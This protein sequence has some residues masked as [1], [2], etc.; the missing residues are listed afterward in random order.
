MSTP[1]ES[2][3]LQD[4]GKFENDP[5]GGYFTVW[6]ILDY[7]MTGTTAALDYIRVGPIFP[8]SSN[9]ELA[10]SMAAEPHTGPIT[11][12]IFDLDTITDDVVEELKDRG[13]E[14]RKLLLTAT[15]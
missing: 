12:S 11:K 1:R 5:E 7:Q 14:V 2:I 4:T 10:K 15:E 6:K 3:T 13:V 8:P 9:T